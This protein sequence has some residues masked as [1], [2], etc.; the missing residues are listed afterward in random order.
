METEPRRR[1][2][3][4]G[5]HR[6]SRG[7]GWTG[8]RRGGG[9]TTC[10]VCSALSANAQTHRTPSPVFRKGLLWWE[11]L[12][13][14]LFQ[15][16]S[17]DLVPHRATGRGGNTWLRPE[18]KRSRHAYCTIYIQ[19]SSSER[20]FKMRR[21]ITESDDLNCVENW[22]EGALA[23]TPVPPPGAKPDFSESCRG[24]AGR[25]PVRP[26]TGQDLLVRG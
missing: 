18:S 4:P 15:T 11:R 25:G 7:A 20:L 9:L 24:V 22:R 10:G 19:S 2:Q 3:P 26:E 5:E 12:P 1:A 14:S 8:R 6:G 16:K 17:R 23:M 21:N 13:Y